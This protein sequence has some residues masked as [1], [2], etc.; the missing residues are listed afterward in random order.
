MWCSGGEGALVAFRGSLIGLAADIGGSIRVP[1][2]S[3][4]LFGAKITSGRMPS[5]GLQ[6]AALGNEGIPCVAGPVCRSAR[7]NEHFMKVIPA[8]EP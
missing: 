1:A 6:H 3:N 2:A 5:D 8:A 4:G 7:D